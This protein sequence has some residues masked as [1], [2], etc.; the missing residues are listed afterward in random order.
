MSAT[1][2]HPAIPCLMLTL[3]V[4]LSLGAVADASALQSHLASADRITMQSSERRLLAS[5]MDQLARCSEHLKTHKITAPTPITQQ[6]Q[7]SLSAILATRP[8]RE[9]SYIPS[10]QHR[11]TLLNLPPPTLS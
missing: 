8:S 10:R 9:S 6:I 3:S 11:L 4:M 1:K 7:P 5:L 2:Q